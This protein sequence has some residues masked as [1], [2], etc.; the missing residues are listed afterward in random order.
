MVS[1]SALV[2]GHEHHGVVKTELRLQSFESV[3]EHRVHIG[4]VTD[5][6]D[7]RA[8]C[9]S[10]SG[11]GS[12]AGGAVTPGAGYV[13]AFGH[14]IEVGTSKRHDGIHAV[15]RTHHSQLGGHPLEDGTFGLT[16]LEEEIEEILH[17]CAPIDDHRG[18]LRLLRTFAAVLVKNWFERAT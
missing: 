16:L 1:L 7:R 18:R 15:L 5:P 9:E 12:D 3:V 13:A 10:L 11:G 14:A 4:V 2:V 8:A 17:A 6:V